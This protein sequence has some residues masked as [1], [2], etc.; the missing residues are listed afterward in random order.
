MCCVYTGMTF[1]V[2]TEADSNDITEHLHDDKPTIGMFG[3][4]GA[5][6]FAVI[7]LGPN[8]QNIVRHS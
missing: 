8:L 6:F 2:K 7:F 4:C 1:E 3:S 5:L